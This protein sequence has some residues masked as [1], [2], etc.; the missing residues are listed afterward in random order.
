[1][2]ALEKWLFFGD[3]IRLQIL[4]LAAH[5]PICGVEIAAALNWHGYRVPPRKLYPLLHALKHAGYLM[6]KCENRR[7][8]YEATSKGRKVIEVAREKVHELATVV[9]YE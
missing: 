9:L 2:D 6:D 5:K 3:F 8:Y 7:K 4:R 1:M